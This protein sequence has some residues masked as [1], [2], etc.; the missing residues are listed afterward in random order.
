MAGRWPWTGS[1]RITA[2]FDPADTA[3]TDL[4]IVDAPQP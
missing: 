1:V 2:R 4:V 3:P